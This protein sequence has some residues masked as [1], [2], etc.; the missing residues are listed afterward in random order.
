MAM[1]D[2]NAA[3]R[4]NIARRENCVREIEAKADARAAGKTKLIPAEAGCNGPIKVHRM[5]RQ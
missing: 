2:K 1:M 3:A 5:G 4:A